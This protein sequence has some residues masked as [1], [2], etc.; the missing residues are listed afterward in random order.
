M[1][2]PNQAP[3]ESRMRQSWGLKLELKAATDNLRGV[4]A[5]SSSQQ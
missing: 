3:C 4:Q 5:Q 2:T 1:N